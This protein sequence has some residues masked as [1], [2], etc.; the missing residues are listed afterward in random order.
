M[1]NPL[2]GA[3]RATLRLHLALAVVA[4]VPLLLTRPGWVSA[5]TKTYLYLDPSRLLRGAWSMWDSSV[6]MG[7]VT[8]Q[9]VGFLWPMGPFFWLGNSLGLPDWVIQRLWWGSIIFIAGA[10][11]AY[12][13]RTLGW[14]GPGIAAASFTYALSPY[15]L[16]LV[17]RLSA[18]LLP[19]AALPLLL[20]FAV[21]AV[22]HR[23]WRYPALFALTVATFGSVNATALLLVGL[24]PA[25]W[26]IH[27]V[28]G[29]RE[30][31]VR[32]V[33]RA[34][35][36]MAVLTVPVSAWWIA[37][38]SVQSTHGLNVLRYSET[39]EVVASAS[40]SHEVLRS[41]GYWFFYGG[42][43]LGPWIEASEPYTQWVPVIALSFL[44][45]ILGLA[46]AAVARWRHRAYF[47]LLLLVGTILA[48]GAYPWDDGPLL[49]RAFQA[50]FAT[51][52]GLA[53]RSLPR[54]VP[55][56][57]LALAVLLGSG[58]ATV[59]RRWPL[60]ERPLGLAVPAVAVLAL[61]P[62]WLGQFVP[63][64]LNR[65]E[66]LP[67]YWYEAAEYLDANPADT[68]VLEIP[69][70]DFASYRW[71]NTVDPVL[72]GLMERPS[73]ARE[74]IPYGSP[75]SANLLNALDLPLQERTAQA[76]AIGPIARLM[77]AG[78]VVV[79]SDLQY[80]RFNTPRP[81]NLWDLVTSG[82]G[83]G[84]PIGFGPGEPNET[85]PDVQLYDELF[86][87]TDPTLPD[88]PEVA[89]LPV[90]DPLP[91]VTTH[92]VT[93]PL[94]VAGDG[95]GLVEAAGA[96]L[97]D[98]SELIRYSA[99][100]NPE[101]IAAALE[102]D[103]ALLLTDSNRKRGERWTHVRHT[104][105]ATETVD[106][107]MLEE[108]LRDNRL[109]VFPD[110][111]ADAQTVT[112][113]RSGIEANATSY[114]NPVTYTP[115]ERPSFA[116]DGDL[117]T[118]WR[119]GAFNDARGERLELTLSEPVTTGHV[120]LSQ[121]TEGL[122]T[123]Y[124][125]EVRLRFD[126]EDPVD[127]TLTEISRTPV[128]QRITF[129]ERSFETL[130]IEILADTVGDIPRF[131][132]ESSVGFNMV[133]IGDDMPLIEEAVR[134]PT[135]LLDAAG[136]DSI[137][138]PLAISVKRQR[139]N[140][141]DISRDDEEPHLV[142]LLRLPTE[143]SFMLNGE[144]RLSGRAEPYTIDAVL[145]RPHEGSVP[146]VRA[147]TTLNGAVT[148]PAAAFDGDTTT[149][150]TTA[151]SAPINQWVEVVLQEPVTIDSLPLTVIA[152]GYHSVPTEIELWVDGE[153]Q[154]RVPLPEIPDGA[155]R[156]ATADVDLDIPEVT[157]SRFRVKLTGVRETLTTDW[158]TNN[159]I[160]QPAAIAEIGLPGERVPELDA[161]FDS[162]CRS[163][164][165]RLDGEPLPVQITGSVDDAL[166]ANTLQVRTCDGEDVVLDGGEHEIRSARGLDTG[167][168]L[169]HIVLRSAPG[170]D[171]TSDDEITLVSEAGAGE[172][173]APARAEDAPQVEVLDDGRY[174]MRLEITGA[175]PDVPFWFVLGQSYNDGWTAE[176]ATHPEPRLVNGYANGWLVIPTEESF[177]VHL[178]F[179][180]QQRVNWA[181]WLSLIAGLGV[182]LLLIRRPR[183]SL[184]APSAMPEPY[185][186][187]LAFRYH[188]ALP[189]RPVAW[190]AGVA[191]GIA[192]WLVAGP[193]VG[194]IVGVA[195]GVAARHE[196]FR[197]W[198]LLASPLALGAAAAYVVYVQLRHAPEA[199]FDWPMEL[200]RPHPIGWLAVWL[201]VTDVIVGRIWQSRSSELED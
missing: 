45:P 82:D 167:I 43:R 27:A 49:G 74:L 26:L 153:P 178:E 11:V 112:V 20:A 196:T 111:G 98:G 107:G 140:P 151:R 80:E 31:T 173:G 69:G 16:T 184:M 157:G 103:A 155:E 191:V 67:H 165:L 176:G 162:G 127:A 44:L 68:R 85:I 38:L 108:D 54:A 143:R 141:T 118:A 164:L 2:A 144:A 3:H 52:A 137:D 104:R 90:E 133:Q 136:A 87:V 84:E 132:A 65:E 139:Q 64:N 119:A 101:E 105:G 163:D 117:R 161:T 92:P 190:F 113:N 135:D 152:D 134:L 50:F 160:P 100:L 42:D 186:S 109:P 22:R 15:L 193:L 174:Q 10:G 4:Y 53:M 73:V 150:W 182:A 102:N 56:V 197:R 198:V 199:T 195:A 18:I 170:G 39:A 61:P 81:R 33:A 34:G 97:I 130:S 122:V 7:T 180:P 99:T 25:L 177:Q 158:I 60:M 169:D 76:D 71:G 8:H 12:L 79:R 166:A 66:T 183:P 131:A 185:S 36:Q 86:F 77:R 159:E 124:I 28:W 59:A 171:A 58:V 146:W 91:I 93:R 201:M 29:A 24:A 9:N 5:D 120:T 106:G 88:P 46:G 95:A 114:G 172:D 75:P 6:G 156:H 1:R 32:D 189:T 179:G 62:L 94:L 63:D 200:S 57:A 72:P 147:S 40:T 70:S 41:L 126:G 121:P 37:G 89:A 142:R 138:H 129:P 48:V 148:T 192:A 168:D 154:E 96:G 125:T 55:L 19:F 83:L 116:V 21:Q 187:V 175:T 30:A 115:E 14:R 194:P 35:A 188:G 110:A 128:G 123:R 149:A 145:G 13:L 78:H 51:D 23:G 17:S 181:L 47:V